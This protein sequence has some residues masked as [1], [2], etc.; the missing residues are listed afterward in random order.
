MTAKGIGALQ[1]RHLQLVDVLGVD[2]GERAVTRQSKVT[3]RGRPLIRVGH[4]SELLF[5]SVCCHRLTGQAHR[6]RDEG[7]GQNTVL[8][9]HIFLLS[10]ATQF[11]ERKLSYSV[12]LGNVSPLSEMPRE[13]RALAS[14]QAVTVDMGGDPKASKQMNSPRARSWRRVLR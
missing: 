4:T 14:F 13:H 1:P 7:A 2:I 12:C 5:V 10:L 11:T 8:H 3:P 9:F 6:Q